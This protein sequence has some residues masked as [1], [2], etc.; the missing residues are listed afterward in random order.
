M[1]M[2]TKPTPGL[3]GWVMQHKSAAVARGGRSLTAAE[4]IAESIRYKAECGRPILSR[5]EIFNPITGEI[6]TDCLS[7]SKAV[8]VL[9]ER[10]D[11]GV[12]VR[13]LIPM[14]ERKGL[15]ERR[16]AWRMVPMVTDT[17]ARKPEYRHDAVA[18]RAAMGDGLLLSIQ[19][20]PHDEK[21]IRTLVTPDG[22]EFLARFLKAPAGAVKTP[23][24][25]DIVRALLAEGKT[26]AEIVQL[27]GMSKQAV[28]YHAR[29]ISNL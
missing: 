22:L 2:H 11:I 26:Q 21:W 14:L 9:R 20:G 18:T 12:T 24:A 4:V 19:Y 17:T 27:S 7:L 28:W 5:G 6:V 25:R 13:K 29:S 16:L 8:E 23:K 15:T 1:T 10:H 3:R